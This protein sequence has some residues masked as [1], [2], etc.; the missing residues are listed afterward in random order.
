MVVLL[1]VHPSLTCSL[2]TA[3]WLTP[4]EVLTLVGA[5]IATAVLE[6]FVRLAE[7][8]GIVGGVSF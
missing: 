1:L 4:V 3:V 2:G 6:A 5:L 7:V 8:F